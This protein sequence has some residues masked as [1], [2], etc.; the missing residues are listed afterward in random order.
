MCSLETSDANDKVASCNVWSGFAWCMDVIEGMQGL[1]SEQGL[2]SRHPTASNSDQELEQFLF[3]LQ[4]R[5]LL[6][7]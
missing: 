5:Q 7:S 6:D 1:W 4:K 3:P 2:P